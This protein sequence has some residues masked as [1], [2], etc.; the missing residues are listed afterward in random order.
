MPLLCRRRFCDGA[1]EVD[2]V[3]AAEE[4]ASDEVL[5]RKGDEETNDEMLAGKESCRDKGPIIISRSI[6]QHYGT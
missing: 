3:P 1:E 4:V 5:A 2:W 6:R